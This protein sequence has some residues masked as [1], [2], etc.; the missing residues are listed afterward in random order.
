MPI[1]TAGR[2]LIAS[3]ITGTGVL[4]NT[5][6]AHIEVGN[7]NTAF[8]AAQTGL[9]GASR[10]RKASPSASA[11]AN[12]LSFSSTFA[13]EEANH[14]W[15]EWGIFNHA[16]AGTMLTRKVENLGTKVSGIWTLNVSITITI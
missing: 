16:T 9:T 8:N 4:Y 14:A 11:S 7:G 5:T 15:L 6:N 3:I 13:G 2:N 10:T 1:T 12:V